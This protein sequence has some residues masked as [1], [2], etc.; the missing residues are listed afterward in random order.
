MEEWLDRQSVCLT[1]YNDTITRRL[2]ERI[3]VADADTLQVKMKDSDVVI[4][5]KLC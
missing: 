1:A 3:T 5:Q 2:V 4:D